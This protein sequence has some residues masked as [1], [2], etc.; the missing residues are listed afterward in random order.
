MEGEQ[1]RAGAELDV[2]EERVPVAGL[3][4]VEPFGSVWV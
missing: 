2:W 4:V 3:S 1:T